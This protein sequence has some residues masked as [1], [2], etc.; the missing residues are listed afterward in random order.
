MP[1]DITER[2]SRNLRPGSAEREMIQPSTAPI[3]VTIA[4]DAPATSAVFFRPVQ[5]AGLANSC[6]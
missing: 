4:A 1:T 2:K 6:R 5:N 3:A